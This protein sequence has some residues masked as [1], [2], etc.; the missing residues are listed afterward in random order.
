MRRWS[1]PAAL[2]VWLAFLFAVEGGIL[3]RA[4]VAAFFLG[5]CHNLTGFNQSRRTVVII[6]GNA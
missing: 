5:C 4:L 1:L 3:P 2:S 6:R